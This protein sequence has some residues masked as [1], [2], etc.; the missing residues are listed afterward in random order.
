ML[1]T[2]RIC[3]HIRSDQADTSPCVMA[4]WKVATSSTNRNQ[5]LKR[6]LNKQKEIYIYT[7]L[8]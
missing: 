6:Q 8:P 2:S 1:R 5:V 4:I 3:R 7:R